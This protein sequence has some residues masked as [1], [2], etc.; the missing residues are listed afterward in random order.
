M[1]QTN[2]KTLPN[3]IYILGESALIFLAL[4][5]CLML[6]NLTYHF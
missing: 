4:V 2:L 1:R 6:S 3:L 5:T